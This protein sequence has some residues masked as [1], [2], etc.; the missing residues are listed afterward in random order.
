MPIKVLLADDHG[1]VREGLRRLLETEPDIRVVGEAADGLEVLK[2]VDDLQPNVV[3]M[4]INMPV[5]DGIAA[6]REI[7]RKYPDTGV[8]VL[9]M[10]KE[11]GHA[12][13]AIQAGA[14]GYLLKNAKAAE[15]ISAIRAVDKGASLVDPMMMTKVLAEF[16]RMATETGTQDGLAG[17]SETELGILRL[18]AA[19]ASNKEIAK[20][21]GLAN[22]TVKNKLTVLFSKIDVVDRTQAAIFALKRGLVPETEE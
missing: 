3:L 9:T 1:L 15:L 12:V 13:R 20:K 4:D 6:T 19:G 5:A 10:H 11:D 7:G 2:M 21:M 22:S 14:R 8:I 17:L 16:R 18:L